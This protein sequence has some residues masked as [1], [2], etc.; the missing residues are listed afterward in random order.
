[1]QFFRLLSKNITI[2]RRG[3]CAT[4][5]EQL[6]PLIFALALMWFYSLR[7]DTKKADTSYIDRAVPFWPSDSKY[8]AYSFPENHRQLIMDMRANKLNVMK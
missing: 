3:V 8:A 1:M 5:A 7:T 2:W 4:I 6:T